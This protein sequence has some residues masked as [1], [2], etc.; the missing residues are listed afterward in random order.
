MEKILRDYCLGK[1]P[2]LEM[3][4]KMYLEFEKIIYKK[5]KERRKDIEHNS[6]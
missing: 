5:I 2:L 1:M 6:N 3:I 4:D